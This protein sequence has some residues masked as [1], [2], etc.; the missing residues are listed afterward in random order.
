MLRV[1]R[2]PRLLLSALMLAALLLGLLAACGSDAAPAVTPTPLATATP[3]ATAA[4]DATSTATATAAPGATATRPIDRGTSP[5]R[6]TGFVPL[7]DPVFLSVQDATH[8]AD[9][10]LV[11]G[12]E[13]MGEARAYPISMIWFHHIVNDTIGGR[14]VLLTY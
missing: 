2:H 11:L 12:M 3:T 1:M 5:P 14:P 6:R 10:D 9:T 7:D 8:L 4:A 13:W